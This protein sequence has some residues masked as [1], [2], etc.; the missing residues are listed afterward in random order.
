M[1]DPNSRAGGSRGAAPGAGRQ[2]VA[3][4]LLV[5]GA[6]LTILSGACTGLFFVGFLIDSST[7]PELSGADLWM[8]PLVVGGPFILVGALMWW[9]GA[10]LRRNSA[11]SP[12]E[13]PKN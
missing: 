10:K 8:A 9:G 2:I 6:V 3:I 5:L 7:G 11:S 4:L 1:T 12:P 13:S